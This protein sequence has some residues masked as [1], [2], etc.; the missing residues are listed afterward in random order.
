MSVLVQGALNGP[1]V[2]LGPE[3]LAREARA[4]VD[5]GAGSLHVHPYG[6]DGRESVAAQDMAAAVAAIR[7]AC[8]GVELGVST[9]EWIASDLPG[10]IAAWRDPLPDMASVNLAEAHHPAVMHALLDR[11]IAIEAGIFGVQDVPALVAT[12][13]AGRCRRILVEIDA[14]EGDQAA[15]AA[16]IDA[17]LDAA[18]VDGVPRLHHGHDAGTWAVL[19]EA[20]RH[21]LDVRVGLEDT[22][23][24]P[25]GTR[26]GS[27]APLVAAAV[28]LL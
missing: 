17:A 20:V 11:G 15:L 2:A 13:L 28:A 19:R 22:A 14:A 1:R 7:A 21:G 3:A 8:P 12:G 23:V 10:A 5:A 26:V 18:G 16:A 27:N 25:D 9:G 6:R 24:L 4:A